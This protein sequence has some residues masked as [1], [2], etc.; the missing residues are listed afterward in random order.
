MPHTQVGLLKHEQNY[1]VTELEGLALV[2]A[3]THFHAYVVGQDLTVY[4]DHAALTSLLRA[5][6]LSGRLMRWS[7]KLQQYKPTI[8]HRPGTLNTVSDALSRIPRTQAL[9]RVMTC[10][11]S[12]T[13]PEDHSNG[14]TSP[15]S[16]DS[17]KEMERLGNLQLEDAKRKVIIDYL[18]T[19]KVPE[20]ATLARK[21]AL[22]NPR[23]SIIDGVLF[24]ED[25]WL[26]GRLQ[27]VVPRKVREQLIQESHDGRF[28]GH[29]AEKRTW[30][31]LR[32][33][34]W[35]PTMCSDIRKC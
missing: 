35:W 16:L 23:F 9:Q 5:P 12:T 4:T 3:L 21:L 13:E 24:H 30:E 7:L 1:A 31:T 18:L 33:Q 17:S 20:D 26:P 19:A 15:C 28:S 10:L 11:T 14:G 34:Y 32:R 2:W 6:K 22:E 29:F 27:A 8:K 25:P